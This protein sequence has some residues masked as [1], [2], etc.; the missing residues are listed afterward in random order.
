MSTHRIGLA[1]WLTG[2]FVGSL[3]LAQEGPDD[4]RTIAVLGTGK[5]A[6]AP[7]V[8]EVNVGVVAQA[9]TA[10]DAL[11]ANNE[12]MGAL[13][14]TLKERGVA[15][16]DV[17]TSSLRINPQYTQPQAQPG[18]PA[19]EFQPRIFAYEVTNTVHI[20]VRDLAKL[21]ELLDA[22]VSSGANRMHGIAFR[23]D[24]DEE[25]LDQARKQAV[26][27]ARRKAELLAG[28]AGVVLGPV[29]T[30]REQGASLPPPRPMMRAA[31]A[32]AAEA[33]A[34]PVAEGEQELRV[35]VDVTYELHLP[36]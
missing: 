26:A 2:L 13:L 1:V 18:R 35:S 36:K 21:G 10:R 9:P 4:V 11:A 29:L 8:A 33:M 6:A 27:D 3:V 24:D 20:T 34:V 31:F 30:I 16:K 19:Q 17:Q 25:L 7:D 15:G 12:A 32:G 14:A 23:I 5:V 22:V 28:E